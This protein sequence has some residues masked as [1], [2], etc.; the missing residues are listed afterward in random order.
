MV[1]VQQAQQYLEGQGITLPAFV[2]AA[3][4]GQAQAIQPCLD[5]HYPPATS[6]L[7][8]LYVLALMALGQGDRY[9]SSQSSPS[10]AGRS[11]RYQ[12][13]ADRWRGQLSVLRGLD[14]HGCAAEL[15]PP[16]PTK[17]GHAGLWVARGGCL[18]EER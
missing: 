14:K 15:I 7:I 9:I 2:L 5:E 16:D 8:Q 11:F 12:A 13:C 6:T 1:T 17:A 4:V 10:G 3:L 18:H